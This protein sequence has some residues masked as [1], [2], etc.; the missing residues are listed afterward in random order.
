MTSPL[1]DVRAHYARGEERSRLES[2]L[3]KIEFART[4]EIVRRHLPPPPAVVADI[5]GGP[6]RYALWLADSGYRVRHRDPVG[7]HVEQL[8]ADAAADQLSVDTAVGDARSLDLPDRSVDAV[9]LLGPLYH[10]TERPERVQALSEAARIVRPGGPVYAAAISRW[11]PRLHGELVERLGERFPAIVDQLESV[12]ETGLLPP[13]FPG[14]FS[15]Y[16]HRPQQLRSE[17]RAA[18]MDVVDLVSIEG[19]SFAL[20]DLEQRLANPD[21]RSV[22]LDAA[23]VVERVPELLGLGPHLLATARLR[24]A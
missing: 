23:R 12:E 10:L 7:L 21:T 14:S 6:G 8:T 4:V 17:I 3:G 9:L 5:G 11:A 24:A 1:D 22:V 18:G 20:P 16:C 13:L 19:L 2:P 15:G